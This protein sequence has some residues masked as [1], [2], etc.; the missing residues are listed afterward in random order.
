[1]PPGRQGGCGARG[2]EARAIPN[3]HRL[4][5]RIVLGDLG[6]KTSAQRQAHRRHELE[7]GFTRHHFHRAI[8]ILPLVT[9]LP[10]RHHPLAPPSPAAP[11]KR[12]PSPPGIHPPPGP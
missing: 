12:M 1:M 3:H 11:G 7:L 10:G 2:V 9:L 4:D 6:Q 5:R 8:N